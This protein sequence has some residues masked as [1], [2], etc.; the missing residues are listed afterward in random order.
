[1]QGAKINNGI[2]LSK[3][4]DRLQLEGNNVITL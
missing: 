1:M 2:V 4:S 3:Q